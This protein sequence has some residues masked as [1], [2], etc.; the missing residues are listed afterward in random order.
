MQGVCIAFEAR[1]ALDS[2]TASE[3]KK[4]KN[5]SQYNGEDGEAIEGKTAH[6]HYTK[7]KAIER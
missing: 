1:L 3:R 7:A 5:R 6:L 4:K 2:R